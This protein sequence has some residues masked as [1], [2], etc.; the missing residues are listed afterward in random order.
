MGELET[1]GNLILGSTIQLFPSVNLVD[2]W[3]GRYEL[4]FKG[5]G[6]RELVFYDQVWAVSFD[7]GSAGTG[8]SVSVQG[9]SYLITID[10]DERTRYFVDTY[11]SNTADLAYN[12]LCPSEEFDCGF[13][14]WTFAIDNGG[15]LD[16]IE[17]NYLGTG[18]G[19]TPVPEPG[20]LKLRKINASA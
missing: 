10:F 6:I 5:S 14:S 2:G 19:S 15:W 12:H 7:T 1:P 4:S 20:T 16:D 18:Q 17:F 9:N 11:G 3:H 8:T 13:I